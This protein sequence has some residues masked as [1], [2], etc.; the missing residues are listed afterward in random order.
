[1]KR[2]HV[3]VVNLKRRISSTSRESDDMVIVV[4]D[5]H[6]NLAQRQIVG[7]DVKHCKNV[8]LDL[9]VDGEEKVFF[10]MLEIRI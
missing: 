10:C 7:S 1:M 2:L 5:F 9:S 6:S 4:A 8:S 3:V